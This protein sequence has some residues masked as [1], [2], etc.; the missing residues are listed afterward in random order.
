[1]LAELLA[2]K[3]NLS[4]KGGSDV[5][6]PEE[7][8]P[9]SGETYY[10]KYCVQLKG[11]FNCPVHCARY[12]EVKN[13]PYAGTRGSTGEFETIMNCGLSCGNLNLPSILK[14][15]N[16]CNQY[17]LNTISAGAAISFAI[18]LYKARIITKKETRGMKLDWGD[19][20]LIIEL[21]H[22]T[23]LRTGLGNILAEGHYNM[24]RMFGKE[25]KKL[26]VHVKGMYRAAFNYTNVAFGL[27]LATSTRGADHLRGMMNAII[28]PDICEKKWGNA[29]I[30]NPTKIYGKHISVAWGQQEYTLADCL[31]RC[32]CGATQW[33]IACPMAG[34]AKDVEGIGRAKILS[35]ATG[36]NVTPKELELVAERIYNLEKAFIV[37]EGIKKKHDMP[38][39]KSFNVPIPRGRLAGA[40]AKKD[41]YNKLLDNYY[42]YMGW[43]QKTGI[44]T[45]VKLEEL[46]LNYVADEL[47]KDAP[48][49]EW[50]GPQLWP[51]NKYPHGGNRA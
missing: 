12:F 41:D 23:A 7:I 25:A 30:A 24:A 17:G 9:I 16:L 18:E 10:K 39:W 40:I 49:K 29:E 35:A 43:D 44:P 31:G 48:Y 38:P 46:G 47:E 42:E 20:R 5:L 19:D 32:K 51:L 4:W 21:I 37:R 1:M 26:C 22:K 11:C 36:W 34:D 28:K 6:L 3:G 14:I 33:E 15:N 27:A 13:G 8:E 45:R 50:V 2:E